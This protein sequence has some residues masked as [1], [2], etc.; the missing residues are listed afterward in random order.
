MTSFPWGWLT[1]VLL[2]LDLLLFGLHLARK[3]LGR[4]IIHLLART[5]LIT[6]EQEATMLKDFGMEQS[7]D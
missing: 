6:T 2:V 5:R 1:L 7:H 3:W 4:Q